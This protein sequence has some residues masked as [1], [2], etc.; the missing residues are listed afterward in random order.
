MST[1]RAHVRNAVSAVVEVVAVVTVVD[2]AS[3]VSRGGNKHSYRSGGNGKER[4]G[5][6]PRPIYL[7]AKSIEHQPAGAIVPATGLIKDPRISSSR[8]DIDSR[9][10]CLSARALVVDSGLPRSTQSKK[11]Q[12]S[13]QGS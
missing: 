1:K 9:Q 2:A 8:R 13:L 3:G 10:Q 12:H 11:L 7:C 6:L 4:P 5:H